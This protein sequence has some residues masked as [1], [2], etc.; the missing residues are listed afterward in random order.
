MHTKHLL[1]SVAALFAVLAAGLHLAARAAT[2]APQGDPG[3]PVVLELFTSQGCSSCP[4]A[5][6]LLSQLGRERSAGVVIPLAFH[7]DYWNYLGWSDPF[8]SP[9]WS[10]RQQAY[11]RIF[12]GN[13]IYTPQLVV[14]GRKECV[15]SQRGE[16]L[17]SIAAARRQASLARVSLSVDPPARAAGAAAPTMRVHAGLTLLHET[18]ERPL[19]LWV[20]LAESGLTTPVR[21]GENA[22]S[23]LRDDFVVRRL[24]KALTLGGAP[25]AE[26]SAQLELP[27]EAGWRQG[28]LAVV[29]FVQDPL[30]LAIEGA[31]ASLPA[32]RNAAAH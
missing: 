32:A 6:R 13:R 9:R 31:A 20:A 8:S 23:T 28:D 1:L 3:T 19:E 24:D 30:T 4:P 21:A 14:N 2:P 25:G 26:R 11:A 29:A 12:G 27:L 7:V 16:V 10:A 5:D 15:G 22:A 18:G 17:Q